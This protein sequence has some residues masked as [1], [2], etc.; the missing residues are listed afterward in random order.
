MRSPR[1][2][3]RIRANMV[4]TRCEYGAN[5]I[6]ANMMRISQIWRKSD[7]SDESGESAVAHCLNTYFPVLTPG[8]GH[9]LPQFQ[10]KPGYTRVFEISAC[11]YGAN[12][13]RIRCEY[14]ANMV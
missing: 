2:P 3:V 10:V 1:E 12:V 9:F 4:R 5:M 11:E 6:D 8:F 14:G 7:E 13:V